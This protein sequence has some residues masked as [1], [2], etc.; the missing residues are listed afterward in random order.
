VTANLLGGIVVLY[1]AGIAGIAAVL[2]AELV[3][4]PRTATHAQLTPAALSRALADGL[5][6]RGTVVTVAGD[7]LAPALHDRAAAAGAEV[8]HYYGAAELSFVAWGPHAEDLRPFPGVDVSVRRGE[9]WV[10]SP[11]LCTGYD[12]PHGP[13]RRAP[14]GAATV[15]DR[16]VLAHGRLV[17]TGRPWALTVGG[18]TVDTGEIERLLQGPARGEVVV[19]GVP[20]DTWG[21]L[22]AVVLTLA[23]DHAPLR[24]LAR[25]ALTG[26]ARP[27]LWYLLDRLPLTPA[28]K[29]DRA[30]VLPLLSHHGG[31]SRRLV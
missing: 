7:R 19:V 30:A 4:D 2:G 17:V 6:L 25:S 27:R 9:I 23:E 5:P 29:V 24:R 22:P 14:D 16:G 3:D 21:A 1:V 26:A 15:G 20:H 11:F 18:A 13:L 28:G 31:A 12:G 10:R 8:H